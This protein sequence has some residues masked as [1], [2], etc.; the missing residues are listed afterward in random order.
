MELFLV[1]I[2]VIVAI[3][4]GKKQIYSLLTSLHLKKPLTISLS[5]FIYPDKAIIRNPS[6][7]RSFNYYKKRKEIFFDENFYSMDVT[8]CVDTPIKILP[9]IK[10]CLFQFFPSGRF[11]PPCS[12]PSSFP[13]RSSSGTRWYLS[14][15]HPYAT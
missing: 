5:Q 13:K 10:I 14:P 8:S 7:S 3:I 2:G 6:E 15:T 9:Y 12:A 1:I 11:M 4:V